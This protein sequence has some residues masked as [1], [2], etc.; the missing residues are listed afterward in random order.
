M[1]RAGRRELKRQ[2]EKEL[3]FERKYSKTIAERQERIDDRLVEAYTVCIG[4]ALNDVYGWKY[5]AI[6]KVV[7]AFCERLCSMGDDDG[8]SYYDLKNELYDK[9]GVEFQWGKDMVRIGK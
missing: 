1:N 8:P 3:A 4:L 7:T 6:N 2:R 5:N 9:T